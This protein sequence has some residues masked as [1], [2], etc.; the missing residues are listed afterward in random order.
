MQSG[1]QLSWRIPVLAGLA[2][3]LV[4][5]GAVPASVQARQ[6]SRFRR[7]FSLVATD[8][9]RALGLKGKARLEVRSDRG[10]EKVNIEAESRR[11][12]AGDQVDA[13]AVNPGVSPDPV[14]LGT[15]TLQQ[16]RAGKVRAELELKNYDGGVLPA[17]LTPV[18]GI[19]EFFVT[20][21]GNIA[22]V[23]LRSTRRSTGGG[24]GGGGG[25][26]TQPLRR[27]IN[28]VATA[29]G[30]AV[31]ASGK[32][33]TETR[34]DGRQK[35]SVEVESD[36]LPAGTVVEISF[37]HSA[38]GAGALSAGTMTLVALDNHVEGEV[39]FKSHEGTP[40]PTGA[41]PV[42]GI[43]SVTIVRQDTGE[44]ILSGAF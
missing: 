17:G 26:D 24:N 31:D 40:L 22:N 12:E 8:A 30:A 23:L 10:R 15:L 1:K 27:R 20:E 2:V 3:A 43:T 4:T 19:T 18:Q 34:D 44:T 14:L 16:A 32:A 7:E 37:T 36:E 29:Q 35:F 33:E 25:G 42:N 5:L 6:N 21:S 39:E 9:G 41:D 13:Y 28:L 11:L 38:N